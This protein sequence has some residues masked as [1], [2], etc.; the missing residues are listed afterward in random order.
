MDVKIEVN[1]QGNGCKVWLG[2]SAV[3]FQNLDDAQAYVA[4]LQERIR[5]TP[6]SF[7]PDAP[8]GAQGDSAL[9]K[10]FCNA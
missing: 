6:V 3:S 10:T 4:K 7:V 1:G 5:A 2:E 8:S 9:K